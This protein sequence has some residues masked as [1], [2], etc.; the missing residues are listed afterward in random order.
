[1]ESHIAFK[2]PRRKE[3][4]SWMFAEYLSRDE[5]E[6]ASKSKEAS[7][8][9]HHGQERETAQRW[10][11]S[12]SQILS[13]LSPRGTYLHVSGPM[14]ALHY[15][16]HSVYIYKYKQVYKKA[17]KFFAQTDAKAWSE[18]TARTDSFNTIISYCMCFLDSLLSTYAPSQTGKSHNFSGWYSHLQRPRAWLEACSGSVIG[19]C[20][21]T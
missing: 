21:L 7:W 20:L 5:W 11:K 16:A 12:C 14:L 13:H 8:G 9:Y 6:P 1:M 15:R 4:A 10:G 19:I 17:Y 2:S 18:S 3:T